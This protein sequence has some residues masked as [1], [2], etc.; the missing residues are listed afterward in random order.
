MLLLQLALLA[1]LLPICSFT[2]GYVWV[3]RRR[4]NPI[5]TLAASVGLGLILTYAASWLIYCATQSLSNGVELQRDGFLAIRATSGLL[6]ILER[7]AIVNLFHTPRVRHAAF[8]FAGRL[9]GLC[10]F[11]A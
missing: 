11:S 2:P 7:R 3:R 10:S 8:A 9:S 1:V 6:G 4:F 5:E